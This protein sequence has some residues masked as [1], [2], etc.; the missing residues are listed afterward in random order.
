MAINHGDAHPE[1]IEIAEYLW[2]LIDELQEHMDEEENVV[3]PLVRRIAQGKPIETDLEALIGALEGEHY[4][5]DE[6]L[7]KIRELSDN[8]TLPPDASASCKALYADLK[9]LEK[10]LHIHVH[11]ENNI[12]FPKAIAMNKMLKKRHLAMHFLKNDVKNNSERIF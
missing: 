9:L 10:D 12:L 8:Y 7:E 1:I 6:W 11:L 5:V 4:E 3:F 2:M